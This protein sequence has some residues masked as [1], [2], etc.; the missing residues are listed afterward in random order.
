MHGGEGGE[1]MLEIIAFALLAGSVGT[2]IGF[3]AGHARGYAK[4]RA[5]GIIVGAVGEKIR[6]GEIPWPD[7]PRSTDVGRHE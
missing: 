1:V 5:F 3:A 7:D 2:V 4:G 6:T